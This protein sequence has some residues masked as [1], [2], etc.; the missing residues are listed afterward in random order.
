MVVEGTAERWG[1]NQVIF[2]RSR[3][4]RPGRAHRQYLRIGAEFRRI[5]YV[6]IVESGRERKHEARAGSRDDGQGLIDWLVIHYIR[7][8]HGLTKTLY[9]YG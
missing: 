4:V 2:T 5:I 1:H 8:V 3:Y 6:C 9:I 7:A